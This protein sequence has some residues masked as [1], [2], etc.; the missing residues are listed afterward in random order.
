M[1]PPA[2]LMR[3]F[4]SSVALAVAAVAFAGPV[5]AMSGYKSSKRPLLVFAP[6][7]ASPA[8]AQQRRAV[9]SL[10]PAFQ[11]RQVVV[12]YIVGDSVSAELGRA[13]RMTA[14]ALRGRYGVGKDDFR[15]VLIGKDGGVKISSST[16]LA[17]RAI[18]DTI[19]AMPMRREEA[20][21]PK[22]G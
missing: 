15:A 4:V 17:A 12:V 16:P 9:R 8:L 11:D 7:R 1:S 13:P 5:P 6:D 22:S 19:D 18:F 10:Q 2:D 21:R 14:E 20:K 3:I